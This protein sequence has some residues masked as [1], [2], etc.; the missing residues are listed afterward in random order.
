MQLKS[1]MLHCFCSEAR[2]SRPER[3]RGV[4]GPFKLCPADPENNH[5]KTRDSLCGPVTRLIENRAIRICFHPVGVF[6]SDGSSTNGRDRDLGANELNE[7]HTCIWSA[8]TIGSQ[9]K[10]APRPSHMEL[11]FPLTPVIVIHWRS[12]SS[13]APYSGQ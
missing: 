13:P 6:L 1:K 12:C 8:R 2:S 11:D 4:N 10:C 7:S 3:G 9:T 5:I